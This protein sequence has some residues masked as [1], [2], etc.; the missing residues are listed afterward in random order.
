MEEELNSKSAATPEP[1]PVHTPA[2]SPVHTPAPSPAPSPLPDR[3]VCL[4]P[5]SN[6]VE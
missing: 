5:A 2:P 1:S 4:P 6:N 3:T